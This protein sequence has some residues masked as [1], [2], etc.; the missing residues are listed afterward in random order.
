MPRHFVGIKYRE[1]VSKS[2]PDL[3]S[4]DNASRTIMK[5]NAKLYHDLLTKCPID[6]HMTPCIILHVLYNPYSQRVS[7]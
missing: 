2:H 7:I 1:D 6:S 3:N 4:R 5:I